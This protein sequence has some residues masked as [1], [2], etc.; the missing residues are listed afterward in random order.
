MDSATKRKEVLSS[1]SRLLD[2]MDSL[3]E[4]CPWDREQTVESLRPLTIEEIYELSDAILKGDEDGMSRELGDILLHIVFYA[5]IGSERG[6]FDMALV[7]DRLCDKLI[8]RHPHVFSSTKVDGTEDV[9][10]NWEQLKRKEK[11]GNRSV[12]S[13]VPSSLPSLV[14]AYRIQ[15][16]A[17]AVGFDWERREDVWDKVKEE[18]AEFEDEVNGKN[19]EEF[20]DLIFSLVNAARLYNINPDTALEITNLKFIQRF[21]YLENETIKQG[22]SLEDMTL[23]EMD[24]IWEKAKAADKGHGMDRA[25]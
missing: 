20:G 19:E 6:I 16:K 10:R 4:K 22:R 17:R 11:N 21:N 18:L 12:L 3:R 15:D 8:H 7:I 14:K 23:A 5:K 2:I 1:F 9:V 13:G 24:E 25:D